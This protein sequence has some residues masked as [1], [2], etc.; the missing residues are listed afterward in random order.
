[1]DGKSLRAISAIDGMPSTTAIIKWLNQHEEFAAQYARA[2]EAQADYYA[3]EIVEIAD[4]EED[5]A[6]ARV[7]VDARKWVAS[8]LRPKKY[9]DRQQLEHSGPDG[10]ALRVEMSA[11]DKAKAVLRVLA[12]A[13]TTTT[14]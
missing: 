11:S 13:K 4:T 3:D 12:E 7:R 10:G 2:K 9:G 6:K 8:K 1:M 5:A 14:K